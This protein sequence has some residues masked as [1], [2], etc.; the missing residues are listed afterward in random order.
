MP[1]EPVKHR[2]P[3][4]GTEGFEQAGSACLHRNR[5]PIQAPLWHMGVGLYPTTLC[6]LRALRQAGFSLDLVERRSVRDG[7]KLCMLVRVCEREREMTCVC[8][9]VGVFSLRYQ[10]SY[11][12]G[13][14]CHVFSF[15]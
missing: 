15:S 6:V 7:P 14:V 11:I 8:E 9:S 12:R 13:A 4:L 10:H 5:S 3:L 1:L 2:H